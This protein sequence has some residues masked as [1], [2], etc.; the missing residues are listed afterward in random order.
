VRITFLVRYTDPGK[1]IGVLVGYMATIGYPFLFV[2]K[3]DRML[4]T[5]FG[6]ESEI[7]STA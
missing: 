2:D 3:L 6:T 4:I 5:F 1:L 7:G